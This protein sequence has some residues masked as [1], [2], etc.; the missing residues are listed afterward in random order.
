MQQRMIHQF[1]AQPGVQH[2]E[3]YSQSEHWK[4]G[5][6]H[7][8]EFTTMD[9]KASKIPGLMYRQFFT[10]EGRLPGQS[11]SIDGWA[12][13]L[14]VH[15][16]DKVKFVWF[17]HSTLLMNING[18][19]V[20]IDPMFGDNAAPVSPFA[21]KR[22][23]ESIFNV[24]DQL[25]TVDL[26]LISHDH[27]DHLDY[28]SISKLKSKAK[29]F[30]VALGVGRHLIKWGIDAHRISEFD[31]WQEAQA[32]SLKISFT[33]SRHFS[34]RGITDRAKSMWG[35]WV[36]QTAQ[37]KIWFSGDGGYGKH[38]TEIGRRLGPFDLGFIE[39]GQYNE[40]WH[41]IHMY[42]EEGVV[43]ALEAGASKVMP[44]HWGSFALAMHHWKEPVD[45]FVNEAL[46]CNLPMILPAQG[47][48]ASLHYEFNEGWWQGIN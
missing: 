14:D 48:P 32:G 36:I 11:W 23:S 31:W 24:I 46:K 47:T 15:Q 1:G 28:G 4:D 9:I 18:F 6:F 38:F 27:Y 22:F 25:P 39:C 30:F 20:L 29:Q 34:G 40:M 17:G 26:V 21:V 43:A 33:P 41:Q 13:A 5:K 10:K 42:P 44:V 37:E 3:R 19:I 2:K 8:L 35:G 16:N 12:S 7:N 45:R